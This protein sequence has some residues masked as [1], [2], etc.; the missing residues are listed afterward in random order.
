MR[1]PPN[2]DVDTTELIP[3]Y[4]SS[5]NYNTGVLASNN[6]VV[7]TNEMTMSILPDGDDPCM[8]HPSGIHPN[9]AQITSEIPVVTVKSK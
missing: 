6:E 2:E 4:P 5:N 8:E 1:D 7:Q 3:T 9:G